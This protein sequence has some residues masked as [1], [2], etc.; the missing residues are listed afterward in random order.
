M[1]S[2]ITSW[3]NTWEVTTNVWKD[4]MK[5]STTTQQSYKLWKA[6]IQSDLIFFPVDYDNFF[7]N[8]DILLHDLKVF[9]SLVCLI[10]Y[11]KHKEI[12]QVMHQ[13]CCWFFLHLEYH[14]IFIHWPFVFILDLYVLDSSFLTRLI[15]HNLRIFFNISWNESVSFHVQFYKRQNYPWTH[16]VPVVTAI[17]DGIPVSIS[18]GVK[19]F[20]LYFIIIAMI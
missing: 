2:S 8:K 9:F 19:E 4:T 16:C 14:S 10:K 11:H 18:F 17:H 15:F 13:T 5:I 3:K 12:F 6:S 1:K 7:K 20:H